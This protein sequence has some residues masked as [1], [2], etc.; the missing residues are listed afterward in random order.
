MKRSTKRLNWAKHQKRWFGKWHLYLG[1]FAG[2]ILAF[3][4]LTG[5]ILVFQD[6]ID[7]ALNPELFEVV[8]Q[9][10]KLSIEAIVP[11]IKQNNPRLK[12]GYLSLGDFKNPNEAYSVTLAK[13]KQQV[14]INPYNGAIGGKRIVSGSFIRVVMDLH[15]T[16]FIPTVG[17][18]IVGLAALCLLV[19]TISGLRLWIPKKW[20][21]VKAST[22]IR[23]GASAKRQNYDW[24]NVLGV[25]SAPVVVI[26]SV[27][28]FCITFSNLVIPLLFMLSG[29]SPMDVA[30]NL[31]AKSV[32]TVS[33]K[34]LALAE[35]IK[36]AQKQMPEAKIAGVLFPAGKT[37]TYRFDLVTGTKPKPGKREMLVMDQ[38]SGKVFL[39]SRTDFP[40]VGE[41]Y[42]AWL[43]PLHFGS[44]GGLPTK[45][46]ALLAGLVPLALFITGFVIWWPRYK[47]QHK[48]AVS[49][50]V[51]ISVKSIVV[52]E[53]ITHC[54]KP[55]I[56]LYFYK[57]FKGGLKYAII[58]LIVGFVM[59]LLY[60]LPSGLVLQPA[61]FVVAFATVMVALNF[62]CASLGQLFNLLFLMPFKR[63]SYPLMRYFAL[64]AAFVISYVGLYMLLLNT[65][66]KIF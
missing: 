31:K 8:A 38:Y 16:L 1:I 29:K 3:V 61:V 26:L 55:G 4:G 57:Q 10:Q 18:Y 21:Q 65:G 30:K 19:L 62:I 5:S 9:K 45:I 37:D 39:N 52:D 66:L 58:T 42:L 25:Y 20:K 47:K 15:R 17:K 34:P 53:K 44:F 27:T 48:K 28:G 32:Y 7:R 64:S 56:W 41:A 23:F 35:M 54:T 24:H 43:T 59:G 6:E 49:Q 11:L 2:G 14:F 40:N 33:A 12:L 22:T 60:G 46:L 13:S 36:L 51:E 50:N 63:G